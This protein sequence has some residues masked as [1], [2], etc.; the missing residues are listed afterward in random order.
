MHIV[1][2]IIYEQSIYELCYLTPWLTIEELFLYKFNPYVIYYILIS[3]P[4]LKQYRH[5][6]EQK[7]AIIKM[8]KD[9][10]LAKSS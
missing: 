1:L 8:I 4:L 3:F 6:N 10:S 5:I 7:K 2:F 9:I